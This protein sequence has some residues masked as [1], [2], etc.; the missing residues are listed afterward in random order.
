[1]DK[2]FEAIYENGVLKPLERLPISDVQHVRVTISDIPATGA[3]VTA[4]F[5]PED[6]EAALG[7]GRSSWSR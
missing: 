2:V 7:Y 5:E 1:V 4:Y 3:D 6:R